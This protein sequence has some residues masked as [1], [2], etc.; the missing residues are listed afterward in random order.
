VLVTA[1]DK[2]AREALEPNVGADIRLVEIEDLGDD[3]VMTVR[4]DNVLDVVVHKGEHQVRFNVPFLE[5]PPEGPRF[6][7]FKALISK[8]LTRL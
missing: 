7:Q 6:E 8:A 4:E 2:P 1:T 5:I 3:A